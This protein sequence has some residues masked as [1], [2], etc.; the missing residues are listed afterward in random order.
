[1]LLIYVTPV[2]FPLYFQAPVRMER[3]LLPVTLALMFSIF[4]QCDVAAHGHH[5]W[6]PARL[7]KLFAFHCTIQAVLRYG[8]CKLRGA[9]NAR[10]HRQQQQEVQRHDARLQQEMLRIASGGKMKKSQ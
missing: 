4:T 5:M 1:M 7:M 10:L 2:L 3:W 9:F 8:E 6:S